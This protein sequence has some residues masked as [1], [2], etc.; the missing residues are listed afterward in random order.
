MI[1]H[2]DKVSFRDSYKELET[3]VAWFEQEE[4]DVDEGLNKFERGLALIEECR[5]RLKDVEVKVVD[6]KK[7]FNLES[8]SDS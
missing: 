2:K 3:I 8:G 4:V 5:K 7:K 6:I 1:K